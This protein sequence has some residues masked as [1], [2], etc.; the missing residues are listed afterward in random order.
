ML[1]TTTSIFGLKFCFDKS[2]AGESWG[3]LESG[4]GGAE[5]VG[6]TRPEQFWS[7]HEYLFEKL[8]GG[9]GGV[10]VEEEGLSFNGS[11]G[12]WGD[13]LSVTELLLLT[14][15]VEGGV[16][17]SILL[18]LSRDPLLLK[19]EEEELWLPE[20]GCRS[21]FEVVG[22]PRFLTTFRHFI[23]TV[24]PQDKVV[25]SLNVK[26]QAGQVRILTNGSMSFLE[27]DRGGSLE[28]EEKFIGDFEEEEE[29]E[30]ISESFWWEMSCGCGRVELELE[31]E[32][33][34]AVEV[35]GLPEW[36]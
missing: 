35:L 14:S 9:G 8:F 11:G 4:G 5:R 18:R 19:L 27:I 7:G 12:G 13:L 34:F 31:L 6:R 26:L 20:W 2:W 25:G 32:E 33:E 23:Q 28:F 24:W 29:M 21:W 22:E 36:W 10:E 30:E 15:V 3:F 17:R 1:E 16:V